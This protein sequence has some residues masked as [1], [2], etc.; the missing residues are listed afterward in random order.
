MVAAGRRRGRRRAVGRGCA[1]GALPAASEL[2]TIAGQLGMTAVLF[3]GIIAPTHLPVLVRALRALVPGI[4]AVDALADS[5]RPHTDWAGVVLRLAVTAALRRGR[6]DVRRPRLSS[7]GGPVSDPSP[8]TAT[9]DW[10]RWQVDPDRA[11]AAAGD[12]RG[13]GPLAAEALVALLV[14]AYSAC[15][16]GPSA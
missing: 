1:G 7:G 10:Q 2:A 4:L 6:V 15:S 9:P 13:P 8:V 3:L 11:L 16:A 5:L 12:H 14:V